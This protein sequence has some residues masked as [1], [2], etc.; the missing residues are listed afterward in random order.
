MESP[1]DGGECRFVPAPA[2]SL[3]LVPRRF[4]PVSRAPLLGHSHDLWFLAWE[5]GK[6]NDV[7]IP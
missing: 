6:A 2:M 3:S 7:Y 4:A 5:D 1:S